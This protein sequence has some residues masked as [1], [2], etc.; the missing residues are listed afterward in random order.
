MN[1]DLERRYSR[2]LSVFYPVAYR[3]ARGAEVVGTYL[4]LAD[5]ARR[6]PS[7]ADAADLAVGGARERLRAAGVNELGSGFRLAGV[8]GLLTAMVLAGFWSVLEL[9]SPPADWGVARQVGPFGSLGI[10]VWATWLLAAAAHA[11]A[12]GRW[13]RWATCGAILITVAVVP[14]A[15]L[16]ELPRPPLFVL[17]PQVVLAIVAIG[18]AGQRQLWLRLLPFAVAAAA[19]ATAAKVLLRGDSYSYSYIQVAPPILGAAG[20][21]L[22]LMVALLGVAFAM[23]GDR[24]GGWALLVLSCP[25]GMLLL[26]P[27]AGALGG[28]LYGGSAPSLAVLAIIIGLAGPA[29]VP[30]A[31]GVRGRRVPRSSTDARCAACGAHLGGAENRP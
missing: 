6:W 19:V 9:K 14:I 3:R 7:V 18:S 17:V 21:T 8:L 13:A 4:E 28:A 10:G 29:L 15:A 2:L 31:V 11:L 24:R 27:L 5:P 23:K 30:L 16:T 12:P 22:L 25:I 1:R 20:V 26:K